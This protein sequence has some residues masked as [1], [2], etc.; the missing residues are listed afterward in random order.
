M[1]IGPSYLLYAHRVLDRRLPTWVTA[2][3][4]LVT[5][6]GW[7]ITFTTPWVVSGWQSTAWG[8]QPVRGDLQ[9]VW[10]TFGSLLIVYSNVHM[11]RAW[12][13]RNPLRRHYNRSLVVAVGAS[14]VFT[15][16]CWV[17]DQLNLAY[18]DFP[19]MQATMSLI[20]CFMLLTPIRKDRLLY[21]SAT[22]LADDVF[23]EWPHPVMVVSPTGVGWRPRYPRITCLPPT[24]TTRWSSGATGISSTTV[25]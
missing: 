12:R 9:W 21:P 24:T 20:W 8:H 17:T 3:T 1:L 18:P 10:T 22:V 13:A 23:R 7:V 4:V 16:A 11:V 14:L 19:Q 25:T 5:V 15:V 2:V 6:A